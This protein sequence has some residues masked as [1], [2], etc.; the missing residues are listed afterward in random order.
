MIVHS[1]RLI[2]LL[3]ICP[4][5]L[6]SQTDGD[7]RSNFTGISATWNTT[8][9]WER[10][11][12][13]T[14]SWVA[15]SNYP[16]SSD[17]VITIS[18][19]DSIQITSPALSLDQLVIEP[20]ASILIAS[21]VVT[22][23]N[24]PGNDI[25]V[26]GRLYVAS[27]GILTT[28][29][30]DPGFIYVAVDGYLELRNGAV[31]GTSLDNYGIFEVNIFSMNNGCTI[32]NYNLL[33]FVNTNPGSSF[34]NPTIDNASLVNYANIS[35][36]TTSTVL[37]TGSSSLNNFF[38]NETT[39]S[40]TITISNAIFGTNN[41]N[42]GI[43]FTNKGILQ[44]E[45][46]YSFSNFPGTISGSGTAV[47]GLINPGI[48]T[49]STGILSVNAA[50]IKPDIGV[51]IN[52][53]NSITAGTG[54]DRLV[55]SGNPT[56]T[57]SSLTITENGTNTPIGVYTIL[58]TSG[59]FI[60][61][62]TEVVTPSNYGPITIVGGNEIRIEKL[63]ILPLTWGNFTAVVNGKDAVELKWN[64]LQESNTSHFEISTSTDGRNFK[65]VGTVKSGGNTNSGHHYNFIH[66][67][68]DNNK[69]N[70]YQ[71]VQIDL[72]GK[73]SRSKIIS[74][75]LNKENLR[76]ISIYNNPVHGMLRIEVKE[77]NVQVS[78]LGLDGKFYKR[79]NLNTGFHQLDVQD[80]ASGVYQILVFNNSKLV[81]TEKVVMV[82]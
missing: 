61:N 67:S 72:D 5:L 50:L 32:N 37:L 57:G 14:F 21:Q 16:T 33:N 9:I 78:V 69:V 76:P 54:Y 28:N 25:Q 26:N 45:G 55:L 46:T 44:G 64:V 47:K 6:F 66:G 3:V 31:I 1:S 80:L 58:T 17:N 68:P 19:G 8:S 11:D 2:I 43:N 20:N 48:S 77:P 75:R 73:S 27:G 4:I 52:L 29:T 59:T 82:K 62:F 56:L 22:V 13:T 36:N 51:V 53:G 15:A 49:S 70:Y 42:A 35:V 10:Y 23:N 41:S 18:S 63:A 7:Y 34:Y 65:T 39:G 74:I 60:G 79:F 40:I 38:I 12:G 71:L 24:G 30:I 81:Q